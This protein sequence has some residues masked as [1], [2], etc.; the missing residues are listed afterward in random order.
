MKPSRRYQHATPY[1]SYFLAAVVALVLAGMAL[2]HYTRQHPTAATVVAAP[3]KLEPASLETLCGGLADSQLPP[4]TL[5]QNQADGAIAQLQ[6]T[7]LSHDLE[8][9][10]RFRALQERYHEEDVAL[11]FLRA[12]GKLFKLDQPLR[13]LRPVNVEIDSANHARVRLRQFYADRQVR[14]T[15]ITV[16]INPQKQVERVEGRYHPTP[17]GL[18][19]K[20]R[21]GIPQATQTAREAL[22]QESTAR[23]DFQVEEAIYFDRQ[24]RP[25]LAYRIVANNKTEGDWEFWVDGNTGGIVDKIPPGK[26]RH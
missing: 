18:K 26:S 22:T 17:S 3:A 2:I 5:R 20:A 21:V 15:E 9:D 19:L 12:F 24:S 8:R 10:P 4:N 1:G 14:G 23:H 6:G 11:C 13:E 7:N 16:H 25:N